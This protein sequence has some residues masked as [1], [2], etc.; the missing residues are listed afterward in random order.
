V[1]DGK[2]AFKSYY[3]SFITALP[4]GEGARMEMRRQPTTD[5][6]FEIYVLDDGP[7]N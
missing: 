5:A 6:E 7:S 4:G 3:G 2:W 1:K